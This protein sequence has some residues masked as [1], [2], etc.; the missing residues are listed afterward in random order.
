M[1]SADIGQNS[2][3]DVSE[4][5]ISFQLLINNNYN[6]SKTSNDIDMKLGPV[7][8]IEKRNTKTPKKNWQIVT[9]LLFFGFMAD[10]DHLGSRI[11]DACSEKLTFLLQE[12][13]YLTKTENRTK[14]S[15][16]QLSY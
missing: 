10:L 16:T 1:Q 9:L 5:R 13:F 15:L 7:N 11:P 14:R 12:T 6:N 3:G 2:D 8:R 4:F